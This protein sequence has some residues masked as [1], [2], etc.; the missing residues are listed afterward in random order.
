[1]TGRRTY[2]NEEKPSD[3]RP[4]EEESSSL[5]KRL[6]DI[7]LG[8]LI[9]PTEVGERLSIKP[10]TI[11]KEVANLVTAQFERSKGEIVALFGREFKRFLDA[12]DVSEEIT[13]ALSDMTVEVKAEINFKRKTPAEKAKGESG[14]SAS[15][16]K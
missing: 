5:W 1:M 10:L 11:S 13:K 9:D 12:T 4:E 14:D 15:N 6:A 3:R 2:G 8:S 7:K 16:V